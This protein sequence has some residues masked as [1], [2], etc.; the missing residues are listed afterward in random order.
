MFNYDVDDLVSDVDM[1]FM[2]VGVVGDYFSDVWD[3]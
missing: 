2:F 1:F 3:V